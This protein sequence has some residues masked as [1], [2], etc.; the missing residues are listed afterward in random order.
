M[1]F[2]CLKGICSC[3]FTFFM[4]GNWSTSE[5]CGTSCAVTTKPN[6]K[7]RNK[8]KNCFIK[9]FLMQIL[10]ELMLIPTD[11]II[12]ELYP[13]LTG[14]FYN[15]FPVMWRPNSGDFLKHPFKV[16]KELKP[17]SQTMNAIVKRFLIRFKSISFDASTL[18]RLMYSLKKYRF[19]I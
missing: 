11:P 2:I 4:P 18:C 9:I 17:A 19:F 7:D 1:S 5:S 14:F 13:L 15:Y 3:T 10:Q 12:P 8:K 16:D 6:T